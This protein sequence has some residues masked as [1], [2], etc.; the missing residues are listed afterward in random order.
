MTAVSVKMLVGATLALSLSG[1]GVAGYQVFSGPQVGIASTASATQF[2]AG[3]GPVSIEDAPHNFYFT[4]AIYSSGGF[5]GSSWAVDYPQAD[6]WIISV[7]RRL[8]GIDI[9]PSDNIVELTDPDLRRFPFLYAVEVG[10]MGLSPAEIQGLRDYLLAGG[11]LFADDFWG[12]REWQYFEYNIRQVLPEYEIV[13]I[14]MDH[15]IFSTYYA[16]DEIIQVP[17]VDNGR[18]GGR[19]DEGD[20]SEVPYC[21]GIFDEE[22]RLMVAIHFNTDLGDAWEWAELPDYPLPYST[23]AYQVAANFIIY[24]MTH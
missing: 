16:I 5:R 3:Y 17:N 19:T 15:P 20:N 4:R 11:F 6:L 1:V 22:G 23:Y 9:Y 2:R 7:L 13:E 21:L 8:T 10:Q 18:R 14:P 24:A 12:T